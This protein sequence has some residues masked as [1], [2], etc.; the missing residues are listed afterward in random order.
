LKA[1]IDSDYITYAAGFAC[2]KTVYY[3]Y[4]KEH[5]NHVFVAEGKE[6]LNP[7]LEENGGEAEFNVV[8]VLKV[9][10]IENC[11]HTVKKSL[12]GIIEATKADSYSIYLTGGNQFRDKIATIKPY[13]GNRDPTHKPVYYKEI[14]DYM[15]KQWGAIV[16]DGIEADDAVC[17]AQHKALAAGEE[18]VIVS[19]DKDLKQVPGWHFD[20]ENQIMYYCDAFGRLFLNDKG[21]LD[22]EGLKFFYAQLIMGDPTDN[23]QGIPKKGPKAAYTALKELTTEWELYQAARKLYIDYYK[24]EA[25]ADRCLLENARLLYLLK[26]EGDEWRPPVSTS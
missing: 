16:T 15:V 25:E 12:G 3:V 7:W 17:M 5:D 26:H 9:E 18:S 20:F 23:I 21:K 24:D 2:Q 13:K 22:G 19:I 8:P 14:R 1:E 11:L 10:P 4:P 6:E